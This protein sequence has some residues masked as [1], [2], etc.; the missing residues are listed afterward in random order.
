MNALRRILLYVTLGAV[1][2]LMV[3][4]VVGA[5]LGQHE[6]T[7]LFNS[8]PLS[9]YWVAVVVLFAA[10]L[11]AFGSMVRRPGMGMMHLGCVLI[12]GAGMWASPWGHRLRSRWLGEKRIRKGF[13]SIGQGQS[14][15]VVFDGRGRHLGRLGFQLKLRRF[16]IDY[17]APAPSHWPLSFAR[18]VTDAEGREAQEQVEI[19]WK[20]RR[21]VI[22]PG[23]D[24]EL[25]VLHY[26][27]DSQYTPGADGIVRVTAHNTDET[28]DLSARVG[29]VATLA[30][31]GVT[32]EVTGLFQMPAHA[33]MPP[34]VGAYVLVTRPGAEPERR[35]AFADAALS[36]RQGEGGLVLRLFPPNYN[37]SAEL[38]R[39]Y[40]RLRRGKIQRE[41]LL[42]VDAHSAATEGYDWWSLD[43]LYPTELAWRWAGRPTLLMDNPRQGMKGVKDFYSHLV[44]VR[45]A[46]ELGETD[47]VIEVND[48]LHYG[49]Y[50]FYQNS[51][52]HRAWTYT[53][54]EAVSDSG[55][56]VVYAG[57]VLLM[58][59]SAV[60]FWLV[61]ALGALNRSRR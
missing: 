30:R 52:D 33:G 4:S 49:G 18:V 39:V 42:T 9:V 1:V 51:Y 46:R 47:K 29:S 14:S 57:F 25:T 3:L 53:L 27:P 45:D 21:P 34:A 48:P 26:E 59:G 6:A 7:E 13:I 38:P 43:M 56:P 19:D 12:L 11:A 2:L 23:T 8:V 40:V 15:D 10:G 32:L 16:W 28:L 50:H 41:E 17:H 31:S 5:F 61:P 37:P 54:L 22:L 58:A 55:L 60:H 35:P 44:V 36:A 20:H 24:I